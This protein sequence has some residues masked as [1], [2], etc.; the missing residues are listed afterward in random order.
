MVLGKF[1]CQ[2]VLLIWITIGLGPT[3]CSVGGGG[4][5]LDIFLSSVSVSFLHLWEMA[6]CKMKNC[7]KELLNPQTTKQ[8]TNSFRRYQY[9]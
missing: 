9:S 8:S 6:Y 5:C 2:N 7:L 3:M 1:L 4:D